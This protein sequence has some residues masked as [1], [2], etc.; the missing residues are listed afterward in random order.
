MSRVGSILVFLVSVLITIT[1]AQE[2]PLTTVNSG[3][4]GRLD[5]LAQANEIRIVFSEP[6]VALG[7][8]PA[9]VDAPFVRIS[10][11]ISGT[12]RWSGTTI[13]IFTPDPK[14]PLPYAT[15]YEVTID[16]A[17]AVSGRTLAR[18]ETFRFT[19]PT[20]RLLQTNWYRRDG[21]IGSPMVA[22][23]R[24]N[25][26]VRAQDVAAHLTASLARHDWNPPAFTPEEETRLRA[27]DPSG[28]K[29]FADK[30]AATRLVAAGGGAVGLRLTSDWDQKRFP[31]SPDLVAFETTSLVR[32]ESWVRLA[33]DA[34]LPSPAGPATPPGEQSFTIRAESAFFIEDFRCTSECDGDAWNPMR[35]R[36]PVR[37][38]DFAA[39][40]RATDI[41]SGE[42]PVQKPSTPRPRPVYAPEA[43]NFLTLEDAGF[44][45]QPPNRKYVVVAAASL[46]AADGQ[47]LGY[48]WLGIVDNWHMRAFTS[49]GDGH[50]VW[51]KDGGAQLPFYARNLLDVRQW[52]SA[53]EPSQLMP[54]LLELQ[55][56]R[57]NSPPAGDGV[58]RRLGVTPDR[59]QS[60][61]LDLSGA[62]RPGGTGL[63]WTAVRE[64]E[65]LP[66]T[67]RV[68]FEAR[69][70]ASVIQ[71]T[72][73]GITV[74]DSPQNT[75]VFVTRL[76]S[77][78]PVAGATVSIVR[79]D[80]STFW[81]GTT[82][83][84]GVAMAPETPLRDPANIWRRQLDFVVTAEKDGDIAYVGS[85][86]NEGIMPWDF[87]TGVN[88]QEREPLL[89]GS[90]FT[91]RGVYR[92][93]EEIHFK[94]ILRHNSPAGV[95]LLPEGTAVLMTVRNAQ[96]RL[97]DERVVRL[98]P[99]SSAEWTMTLPA[100]GAL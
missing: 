7:R 82:G 52:A 73:L 64:G 41:T 61:G 47:T 85:D 62:L 79:M 56:D 34:A 14:Q 6:M 78:D 13:L 17:T 50:G 49:F 76:D 80:N 26:P 27:L 20:V 31:A 96:N 39:A 95:R 84:D 12:F 21:T 99:W 8:I 24:F 91:D 30:V 69:T 19:T 28:L 2:A 42:Q 55:K 67:R 92:L 48:P 38:A 86:W 35:V 74:K 93:G 51:E 43:S 10:P 1:A 11:A 100:D 94:A 57:F 87:G 44:N 60:H 70:R 9:K 88:L 5:S 90:V 54:R 59:V 40:L 89:R 15:S 75:L 22:L 32:P 3:P 65:L 81:R 98:T 45:A 77:G 37:V 25:Q 33:L 63:V 58:N 53:L 71:V 29:S 18:A 66:R 68:G 36:A 23:L 72:N 83:A 97:V 46:R 16:G 4:Q